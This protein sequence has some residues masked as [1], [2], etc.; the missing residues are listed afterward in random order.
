MKCEAEGELEDIYSEAG[1]EEGEAGQDVE[2][3][4]LLPHQ[5]VGQ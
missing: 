5:G 3:G 1:E 4:K 2:E